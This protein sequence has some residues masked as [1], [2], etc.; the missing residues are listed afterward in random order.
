MVV[1]SRTPL[2]PVVVLSTA[3]EATPSEF[4]V[5]D[6]ATNQHG[7]SVSL[8]FICILW[9]SVKFEILLFPRHRRDARHAELETTRS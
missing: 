8:P 9:R 7:L 5:T 6:V 3:T 2:P 4:N 1:V